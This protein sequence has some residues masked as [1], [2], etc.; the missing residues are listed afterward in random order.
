MLHSDSPII[1]LSYPK[2]GRSWLF[3]ILGKYL[4]IKYNLPDKKSI[5][6]ITQYDKFNL[7]PIKRIHAGYSYEDPKK[8]MNEIIKEQNNVILMHRDIKDTIVSYYHDCKGRKGYKGDLHTFIRSINGISNII[9]FYNQAGN[10]NIIGTFSY[11]NLTY[12]TL[13]EFQRF[14]R[15]ISNESIDLK[16]A[17]NAVR[18]CSF[19]NLYNLERKKKFYM[20][21]SKNF[22]KTR[23]GKIGS[24][25][26]EMSDDDIEFINRTLDSHVSYNHV[27]KLLHTPI[28]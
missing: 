10:C 13:Q 23:K 12:Y 27:W 26:E 8:Y 20:R 7:K 16:K 11:E 18:F 6:F 1:F 24:Y 28:N 25:K 17:E 3:A 2:C 9:D 5:D 14:Y 22:F 19:Q 21:G 4:S 15:L